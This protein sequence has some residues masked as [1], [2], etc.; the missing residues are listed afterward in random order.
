MMSGEPQT[1]PALLARPLEEHGQI[2]AALAAERDTARL[3]E[4]IP[5]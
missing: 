5:D 4:P 1:A 3:V 2:G